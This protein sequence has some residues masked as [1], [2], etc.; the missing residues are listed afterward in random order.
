M[1]EIREHKDEV[2]TIDIQDK[3]TYIISTDHNKAGSSFKHVKLIKDSVI[4]NIGVPGEQARR[5]EPPG[6]D[7]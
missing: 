1:Y 7:L 3:I 6:R 5:G 4:D 2:S